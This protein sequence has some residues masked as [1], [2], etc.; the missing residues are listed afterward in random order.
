MKKTLLFKFIAFSL[1]ALLS[2]RMVSAQVSLPHYDGFDYTVT[3]AL[4]I[5]TGYSVNSA[6]SDD[7]LIANGNLST[8]GLSA[9][10]GNKITF[11]G[12]GTDVAKAVVTQT[13][14]TVFYSFMMNV[15]NLG[16][17]N[18]TGG[19]FTGFGQNTTTF[20]ATVWTGLDGTG[21]KIGINPK[22]STSVNMVWASGTQTLNSTVFVVVSYEFVT[23]TGND[24]VNIWVNP[25]S[26]TFGG[27]TAPAASATATNL[28]GTDLTGIYQ[29]FIRQDSDT[30]TPTMEM[31]ELRIGTSWADVTPASAVADVTAPSFTAIPTDGD[32]DV[33]INAP[34]V[35]TFDEAIR[36]IDDSEII[37][38]NVAALLTLK[39]T[40]AAGADVAFTASIDAD[41][42][43]ITVTPAADFKNSQVY[44]AAI[45][46]VEDA[47][48]NA[49][50]VSSM[51]FTTI[52]SSA[53]SISD[54]AITETAPYYAGDDVTITWTSSNVT[55]VKIEAWIPSEN[56]W[57]ELFATT[58]SD[59]TETFTIPADAQYSAAYKIRVTDVANALVT[60][61]SSVFTV[62]AVVND[63]LALR[64]QPTGAFVKYTGI[65]TVTFARTTRNQKYIQDATAAV[66]IDDN[67]TAPGFIT[68]TYAIGDGITNV[69]GKI[70]LYGGL[71]EFTPTAITGEPATGI[72]ILPEVRTLSSLTS[73]DQCKLIKIENFSFKTPRTFVKSLTYAIDGYDSLAIAFRTVFAESDYIGGQAPVGLISSI[74]LVGQYNTQMQI[75]ARSWSD[76]IIPTA[77]TVTSPVGG[78]SY[79]QGSTQ[80]ITWTTTN[81]T[82]DVKI[83]LTGSNPS[84]IVASV[85]NTGSYTW[86]IP[87]SLAVASDFKVMISD[88]VD[89]DP[90]GESAAAF[91][92]TEKPFVT[93]ALVI[94]EIMYTSPDV[95]A[96]QEWVELYNNGTTSVDMGGFYIL[97]SDALHKADPIVLPAGA[98]LA[99]GEYYTIETSDDGKPEL[100]PFVPDFVS[101]K[102]N[103]GKADEVKLFH[104][105]GQLIDSVKY[106]CVAPW[107][108]SP[109]GGGSSLTLCDP[110]L[111]NSLASSWS[112]S[113]DEFIT[114]QST[115]ILATPGSGCVLH[116]AVA[117]KLQSG[118]SVYPNP[119]SDNLYI[120]NPVNEQ[121]E[122]TVLS[123]TGKPVKSMQAKQGITSVDLSDLPKGI[124][125]VKMQNKT[126]RKTQTQKVV[127]R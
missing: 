82:G 45:S 106:D 88:A 13:S 117:P 109:N 34:I 29:V 63:L 99:P 44:Y 70:V 95:S 43:I 9:S 38:A 22:T 57:N 56:I 23:N 108:T 58:P 81:F 122:I 121:L 8:D 60:S 37:D 77:V 83:E 12:V 36:N 116:T 21:Y 4:T 112:A 72:E 59:G 24:I 19:Y 93:P 123:A 35:L 30:E 124:Y 61:E 69:V 16:S 79:V 107:P 51:T 119:T 102:F 91:S 71:I 115:T 3:Q 87:E 47:A 118:I 114:L 104:S 17:L 105:N 110:N 66:L 96:K 113:L 64:A 67:T 1:F 85:A 125:M 74:V 49:T 54:V 101:I 46:P 11:A 80:N 5:Q 42:K 75:T 18:A 6:S 41:K 84:V 10:T 39:E 103:F 40:D 120:S 98:V 53:A 90:I 55:D 86:D 27:A 14:G 68:G 94:T 111:D 89:G 50:E 97:D 48:N 25:S 62:I 92:I 26:S 78:E 73:A 2:V 100:F 20:G 31:D 15:T 33:A 32:I 28:T 52:A 76:M 65:A 126:S 7:I 127:V